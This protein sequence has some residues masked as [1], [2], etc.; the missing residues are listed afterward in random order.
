[1]IK[2]ESQNLV[3]R[4]PGA[5][6]ID[7]AEAV[8]IAIEPE[9]KLGFAG[10]D[11]G[12]EHADTGLELRP[13]NLNGRKISAEAAFLE[14]RAGKLRRV[15]RRHAPSSRFSGCAHYQSGFGT[16]GHPAPQR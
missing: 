11:E 12:A 5:I 8:S 13:W 7:N 9:A 6:F 10:A 2:G 4:E 1:M 16:K 3:G 15:K 14:L